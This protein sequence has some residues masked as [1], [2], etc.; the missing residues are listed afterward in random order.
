MTRLRLSMLAL[1]CLVVSGAA[2]AHA[3]DTSPAPADSAQKTLVMI[4]GK[5]SHGPGA[6]EFNAGVQLLAR[7]LQGVSELETRVYL[8]GWPDNPRAFD[9]ADSVLLYMDGG[10]KH[11]LLVDDRLAQ[12]GKLMDQGVGLACVH[13]AV[14]IPQ[15]DGGPE[16]LDWIGGY[17][18]KGFSTNPHWV[19][20]FSD[21]PQHPITRGV[22]PHAINDEWYFNMRFQP[23]RSG[24]VA[25]LKATPDDKV[26]EDRRMT[27]T[28]REQLGRE[29]VVA[30]AYER[31]NGGRGFGH[32]GG[33]F[34]V[35]WGD[36][37][38]R[39]LVLNALLW[40]AHV[41]VPKGGVVSQVSEED[42]A[43][44][45]DPKPAPT[46]KKSGS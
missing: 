1:L 32:T 12:L 33:H 41:E 3:A 31:A 14:E 46:R 45:L 38:F 26:R 25:I 9:G 40:T 15:D 34:H 44:N 21:L 20:S 22:E 23:E 13:Y 2:D 18:E 16:L 43:R 35:S 24:L 10:A 28:T 39:K 11:E 27:D 36:D 5:P 7:C 19:A 6:H 17:Y 29:E 37:N 8:N 42:L 30:W 4:A